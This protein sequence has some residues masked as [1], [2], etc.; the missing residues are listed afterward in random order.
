MRAWYHVL[1][2]VLLCGAVQGQDGMTTTLAGSGKVGFADG[3]GANASF[4]YPRWVVI[5]ADGLFVVSDGL[6]DMSD[7]TK[8]ALRRVSAGGDVTTLMINSSTVTIPRIWGFSLEPDEKTAIISFGRAH[9]VSRL[10]IASGAVTLIAGSNVVGFADGQGTAVR[11]NFPSFVECDAVGN[12][13]ISDMYNHVIRV[14]TIGTV[15]T[16]AGGG[17]AGCTR[18]GYA[19]GFGSAATFTSPRGLAINGGVLY[20]A[21]QTSVRAV[22]ISTKAVTTVAGIGSES[23]IWSR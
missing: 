21:S 14:L 4:A 2:L 17:C 22:V 19:N 5:G 23:I 15:T 6:F 13:Y 11:F 3:R 18:G 1:A 10:T 20:V 9:T 7:G 8:S 12:A 16:L